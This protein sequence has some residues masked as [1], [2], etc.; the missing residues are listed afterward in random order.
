[1]DRAAGGGS[2]GDDLRPGGFVE[3]QGRAAD[4]GQRTA[5]SGQRTADS[6][7]LGVAGTGGERKGEAHEWLGK[8]G[9]KGKKVICR[10]RAE[11]E[12]DTEGARVRWGSG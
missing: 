3:G 8:D 4:S 6:G 1:V 7:Q 9:A 12:S 11:H 10:A 5:D 2:G